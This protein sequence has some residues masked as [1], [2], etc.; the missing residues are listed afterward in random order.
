MSD[1]AYTAGMEGRQIKAA[2]AL[3]GWSQDELC[4]RSK[5][6]RATLTDLEN[7]TGDPR[8]SSMTAVEEAFRKHAVVFT[9]DG[10]SIGVRAPRGGR[11]AKPK[12]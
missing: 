2:R 6:S 10:T 9:D 1:S 7:E 4:E 8:K 3:L 11:D 5:I 12:K